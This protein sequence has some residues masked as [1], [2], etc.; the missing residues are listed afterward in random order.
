MMVALEAMAARAR[1]GRSEFHVLRRLSL[2]RRSRVAVARAK[3]GEG[4]S[5]RR[6][7]PRRGVTELIAHTHGLGSCEIQ[8]SCDQCHDAPSCHAA[9]ECRLNSVITLSQEDVLRFLSLQRCWKDEDYQGIGSIPPGQ[10]EGGPLRK[11]GRSRSII[12]NNTQLCCTS[13]DPMIHHQDHN[14]GEA[15]GSSITAPC[16][17]RLAVDLQEGDVLTLLENIGRKAEVNTNHRIDEES[18][19]QVIHENGSSSHEPE[20]DSTNSGGEREESFAS[21]ANAIIGDPT[22]G[23]RTRSA[24]ANECL[25]AYFLSQIEPKKTEEALLDP[26]WISSMQEELNQ[27]ERNKF[28]KLVSVLKN[29]SIIG[30]K[31]VFRN[32]MDENGIVTRNKAKLLA[33]GYS[34]EEGIDYDE[35]FAPVSRLEALRIFLA[36][37]AHSNFK[38]YQMDLKSAFL[39]GELEKEVYAQQPPGFEDPKF[40]NFVY[41][42]LK[43]LYRLKQAPR[44]WYDTLSEFLIKHGFTRGTIDKTL[45]YKKHGDDMILVQIYIDDIIF[46]STNEKL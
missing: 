8:R 44:A 7:R 26:D 9:H 13:S 42:L 46:V 27:F 14:A 45:S 15:S 28:W 24:T 16:D 31:W 18:T 34:Q 39:N 1:Q 21:H 41:K 11:R 36:F 23:V 35:T 30:T 40:P 25:H 43:S 10:N 32:K 12:L 5:R 2:K 33:K 20:F 29:R 4:P 22:D 3:A 6:G 37:V 38:V 19:E 17:F